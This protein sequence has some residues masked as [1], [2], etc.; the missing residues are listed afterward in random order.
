MFIAPVLNDP[1]VAPIGVVQ[2][3]EAVQD[4]AS[5]D[6]NEIVDDWPTSILDGEKGLIETVGASGVYAIV[7]TKEEYTASPV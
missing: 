2:K 6:V 5:V 3:P 4:V 7:I 1:P